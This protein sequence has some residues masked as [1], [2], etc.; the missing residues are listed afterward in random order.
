MKNYLIFAGVG[1][2]ALIGTSA[3][4]AAAPDDQRIWPTLASGL[5]V[6]SGGMG[7]YLL[8]RRRERRTLSAEADS[9]ERQ[10][11]NDTA[12]KGFV[13]ALVLAVALLA[14]IAVFELQH[15]S[16]IL[17]TGYL[18]ILLASYYIRYTLKLRSHV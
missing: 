7:S 14:G 8:R 1:I 13:D 16:L 9:F 15:L 10:V 5:V 4:G 2:L 12:A 6:F 11:A 17:I 18:T 3:W